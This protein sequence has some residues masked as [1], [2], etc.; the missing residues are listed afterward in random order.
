MIMATDFQPD[1][2]TAAMQAIGLLN[3]ETAVGLSQK[4]QDFESESLELGADHSQKVKVAPTSK[5]CAFWPAP[6]AVSRLKPKE[7]IQT[8]INLARSGSRDANYRVAISSAWL[9]TLYAPDEG[10]H[11]LAWH[12]NS[13]KREQRLMAAGALRAAG[14]Y[15]APLALKLFQSHGDPYVRLNLALGLIGQ[16]LAIPEVC[17]ELEQILS[18]RNDKWCQSEVGLIHFVSNRPIGKESDPDT[19]P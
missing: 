13:E 15:G 16:R 4:V 12:L 9:L 5:D 3:L 8:V 7:G 14:H 1:V 19:T 11:Y 18:I 2:R 6:T 17:D 10:M